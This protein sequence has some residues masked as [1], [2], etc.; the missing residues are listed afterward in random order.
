MF[1]LIDADGNEIGSATTQAEAEKQ[2]KTYAK[3]KFSKVDVIQFGYEQKII[4]GQLTSYNVDDQSA[5]VSMEKSRSSYGG[6][7]Q[8]VNLRGSTRYY[9]ATEKNLKLAEE[10]EAKGREALRVKTE[11]DE[12]KEQLEKNINLEY[13]GIKER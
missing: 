6:A 8:K 13:F 7:R 1:Y 12:L 2:A 9:E 3:Q 10:I 5:W 4:R 11:A